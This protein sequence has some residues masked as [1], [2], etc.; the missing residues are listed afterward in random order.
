[1]GVVLMLGLSLLPQTRPEHPPG[2]VLCSSLE[3]PEVPPGNQECSTPEENPRQPL[4]HGKSPGA[5]LWRRTM[6]FACLRHFTASFQY[7][8]LSFDFSLTPEKCGLC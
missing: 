8:G 4:A 2:L 1:M 6:P 7:P 3:V 5:P